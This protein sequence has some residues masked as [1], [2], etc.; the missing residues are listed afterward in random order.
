MR[1]ILRA[2]WVLNGVAGAEEAPPRAPVNAE[3]GL[4]TFAGCELVPTAWADGDSFSV[5]FPDGSI[6]TIRLYGVDCFE[7]SDRE[8]TGKRRLRAQ[9]RYF[10]I[11]KSGGSQQSS[12]IAAKKLG[13]EATERL[14]EL[15]GKKF[16]V[17]TAWADG[18]GSPNFKRYYGFITEADGRDLG[19]VLVGEG[20]ARAF[21]VARARSMGVTQSEY[22]QRLEDEELLAAS[23]RVGAWSLTNWDSLPEQRR[24]ERAQEEEENLR[25]APLEKSSINPNT[26]ARDELM[27]L[28]GVGEVTA[29]RI[30]EERENEKFLTVE[31]LLRVPG[32]GRKTAEKFAPYLVF[33]KPVKEN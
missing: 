20:L 3:T 19:R 8:E 15:L 17:H 22:K 31:D 29:I 24:V 1:R 25:A 9:R 6:H 30:M 18:R 26:A 4:M 27:R 5:K 7:T 33:S 12:I 11:A 10:G 16:A 13:R 28:P 14:Q 23:R 32:I 2:L 21:G